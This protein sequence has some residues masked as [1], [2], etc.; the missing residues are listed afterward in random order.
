MSNVVAHV[1]LLVI[2]QAG[3]D[4]ADDSALAK[5]WLKLS[6]E[7][8]DAYVFAST[9]APD[10]HYRALPQPIFRH[11][12]PARG[13]D[14]GAVYLWVDAHDRPAAVG[15]IFAWSTGEPTRNVTHEFHSLADVPL[16]VRYH[17]TTPWKPKSAGLDWRAIPEA[18]LPAETKTAR[19]RQARDLTRRFSA[20]SIDHQ[21]GRWELR[22]VPQPVHTF[23]LTDLSGTRTGAL[24]AVCQGTDPELW[25]VLETR[26]A[27]PE[28]IAWHYAFA[29][30]T[31]Y[32]LRARLDDR[33]V[34]SCEKY[35][36]GTNDAAHWIEMVAA[37]VN[38][39]VDTK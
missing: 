34:W 36:H 15:D 25:L 22:V 26:P 27:T 4:N 17:Q 7:H 38:V 1:L 10:A 2:T 9:N 14:I 30:F 6:R 29:A 23:D 11:A 21:G 33:D 16:D 37:R 8:A 20:N 24:F 31:D 3:A 12:Q 32:A 5:A 28:G 19:L 39:T 35:V 13:N 18:P